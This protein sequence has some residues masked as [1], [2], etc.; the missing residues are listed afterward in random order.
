MY[1]LYALI[2]VVAGFGVAAFLSHRA[3]ALLGKSVNPYA[4]LGWL[5][6]IALLVGTPLA[7]WSLPV[8]LVFIASAYCIITAVGAVR[9]YALRL[10]PA[11]SRRLIGAMVSRALGIA[12]FTTIWVSRLHD[13]V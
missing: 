3:V 1:N 7:L 4:G 5:I 9:T 12:I 11:A 10:P 13:A 2:I 6:V 8:G